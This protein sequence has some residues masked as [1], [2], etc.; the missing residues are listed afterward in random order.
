MRRGDLAALDVDD[1][2]DEIFAA[3]KKLLK[4]LWDE[5]L[6]LRLLGISLTNVTKDHYEQ[7]SLFPD[8]G[9]ERARKLDRA[10]DSIRARY[11]TDA[12]FRARDGRKD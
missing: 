10:L 1:T 12:V 7:Y 2:P 9:R 8:R 5:K 4:E 11:G 6:P 3:A